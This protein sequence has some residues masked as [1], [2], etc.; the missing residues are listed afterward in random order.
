[1]HW[2]MGTTSH[3]HAQAAGPHYLCCGPLILLS[4][5]LHCSRHRPCVGSSICSFTQAA[6]LCMHTC[7]DDIG[8]AAAS[9]SQNGQ[10]EVPTCSSGTSTNWRLTR[11]AVQKSSSSTVSR[12][13]SQILPSQ[14][15]LAR[16]FLGLPGRR[17]WIVVWFETW[18]QGGRV[19]VAARCTAQGCGTARFTQGKPTC[20]VSMGCRLGHSGCTGLAACMLRERALLHYTQEDNTEPVLQSL[21]CSWG[22]TCGAHSAAG[23]PHAHRRLSLQPLHCEVQAHHVCIGHD[24]PL[25]GVHDKGRPRG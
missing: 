25:P 15:T 13:R 9:Q 6:S 1:M 14:S 7:A 3:Q 20:Q 21:T 22:T 10:V 12:A 24:V 8:C 4:L 17:T 19:K 16:H 18:Q 23:A 5:A 11:S 2:C